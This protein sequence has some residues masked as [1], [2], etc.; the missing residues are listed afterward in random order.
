MVPVA[1]GPQ[2]IATQHSI[3]HNGKR[4]QIFL[5]NRLWKHIRKL[6]IFFFFLSTQEGHR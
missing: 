5:K 2:E 4:E 6:G 3:R 1:L